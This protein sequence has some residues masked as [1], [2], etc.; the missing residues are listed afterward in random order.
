MKKGQ[1]AKYYT[2]NVDSAKYKENEKA[3]ATCVLPVQDFL[4]CVP[5]NV[6]KPNISNRDT[7][8]NN[9]FSLE[10]MLCFVL[11]SIKINKIILSLYIGS[12][13]VSYTHL[14]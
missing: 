1:I 13:S 5:I 8:T 2:R 12:L 10:I 3:V 11:F 14:N 7:Y 6:S 9:I 4:H